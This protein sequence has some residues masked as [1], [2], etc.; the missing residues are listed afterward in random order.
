MGIRNLRAV[1]ILVAFVCAVACGRTATARQ[2]DVNPDEDA[3]SSRREDEDVITNY[4]SQLEQTEKLVADRINSLK[5]LI[6]QL[7]QSRQVASQ[8]WS[9][10]NALN[11][12]LND[13]AT[14]YLRNEPRIIADLKEKH[15]RE[16]PSP[17]PPRPDPEK[18]D[19]DKN[20][21]RGIPSTS[22][23]TTSTSTYDASGEARAAANAQVN[24]YRTEIA[25]AQAQYQWLLG[26]IAQ[27]V[28]SIKRGN[29]ERSRL[30]QIL[31]VKYANLGNV[32]KSM[33]YTRLSLAIKQDI[34]TVGRPP[35]V[36]FSK[37]WLALL[38]RASGRDIE[39]EKLFASSKPVLQKDP[40]LEGAI[41]VE[42]ARLYER[43]GQSGKLRDL[44][45]GITQSVKRVSNKGRDDLKVADGDYP[46]VHIFKLVNSCALLEYGGELDRAEARYR[47]CLEL[48]GQHLGE[49]HPDT[50]IVLS[51]LAGLR[52]RQGGWA[53][54]A[55]LQDR[56]NRVMLRYIT[57]VLPALNDAD[58]LTFLNSGF[59][60]S[61][62]AGLSLGLERRED[63]S[64]ATL[65]A[66]WTLNGKA[67]VQEALAAW[68]LAVRREEQSAERQAVAQLRAVRDR[69]ASL[70][71]AGVR[72]NGLLERRRELSR[73]SELESGLV[74]KLGLA[75]SR[76]SR[77]EPWVGL[78]DVRGAIPHDAVLIEIAR[79]D[80]RNF[81]SLSAGREWLEPHYAAWIIPAP[82]RDA[83]QV[84]DLGPAGPIE[85]AVQAVRATIHPESA[86]L[87]DRGE[88]DVEHE[89]HGVLKPLS[90]LVLEP[91]LP[92]IGPARRWI[93]SPDA[94]L[95]LVPW[96][97]LPLPSSANRPLYAIE[98]HPISLV[99]TGRNL[100]DA[101]GGGRANPSLIM[102]DPNYDSTQL[103][104]R[105]I[106]MA[107]PPS[108]DQSL[109]RAVAPDPQPDS[110]RLFGMGSVSRL[111]GTG[112]EAR[113]IV[114]HLKVYTG[115]MPTLFTREDA[116]ESTLRKYPSPRVLVLST[117]GFTFDEPGPRP[118]PGGRS[119]SGAGSPRQGSGH[120]PANPLLR[121][122]LLLAG[123]NKGLKSLHP[124]D[125]DGVL[126]GLEI[127]GYD[128]RGTELVVLSA[129]E[130]GLGR[131]RDGEGVAGL[132]Q[133]FQLAGARSVVATLW[134]VP[135]AESAALMADFF[136]ELAKG[137]DKAEAL[138]AAQLAQ[139]RQRRKEYG[140]AHPYF[141]G[142]YTLTGNPGPGWQ[143]STSKELASTPL[144]TPEDEPRTRDLAQA[145]G[146]ATMT[147]SAVPSLLTTRG[148]S[149]ATER[150][151]VTVPVPPSRPTGPAGLATRQSPMPWALPVV[152]LCLLT[153]VA[154]WC[155][156]RYND[157]RR[158][159]RISGMPADPHAPPPRAQG[160][161]PRRRVVCSCG[162]RLK[163]S[164]ASI[165]R[166]VRCPRCGAVM[167]IP[168]VESGSR[169]P[170]SGS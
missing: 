70:S 37:L 73:L 49:G 51:R 54:A 22:T 133:A 101:S 63:P 35:T 169:R 142:A 136:D 65:S 166:R 160:D 103:A 6:G 134:K 27:L 115:I 111:P 155:G 102:A 157:R 41:R 28:D 152:M 57:R 60:E 162:A 13:Y 106:R 168:E 50:A 137:Q 68:D 109:N 18:S 163:V 124:G 91:M 69:L 98:R 42:L 132:R 140:A 83:V 43:T 9:E 20:P 113:A 44:L 66:G 21:Y 56:A 77:G 108:P 120:L 55:E 12:D 30:L 38:C 24:L 89:L 149:P 1:L 122:G 145:P 95:W 26:E 46:E 86:V 52:A 131:V 117:H 87:D 112:V 100:L 147:V 31:A 33:A 4:I 81:R 72:P 93:I 80:V 158:V 144:P 165:G 121:C 123:C 153:P 84:V 40:Y 164:E 135:D 32:S 29:L 128:L 148:P 76:S 138:R 82:G 19:P 161:D 126:T 3:V 8:L 34:L 39:A 116:L 150:A 25:R 78:D 36:A 62:Q 154:C 59:R 107:R 170:S 79:F 118:G 104:S 5:P 71:Y 15:D 85:D 53:E 110:S 45:P 7:N 14:W 97:A 2:S 47:R 92:L 16:H 127:V 10:L 141:W 156:W 48:V 94:A 159:R 99:L 96:A 125:E 74:N 17:A 90:R 139:I 114:P 130:T 119:S 67:V 129:C 61:F 58:Q 143:G 105:P 167:T 23:A 75:V 146:E 88:P 151:P 11:N 64:L